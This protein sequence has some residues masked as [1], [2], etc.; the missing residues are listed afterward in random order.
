MASGLDGV[1]AVRVVGVAL[2]QED[3]IAITLFLKEMET[4]AQDLVEV[5]MKKTVT[6]NDVQVNA[7]A[8]SL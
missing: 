2:E 5:L 6:N 1:P 8:Y 4:T 7:T 3:G